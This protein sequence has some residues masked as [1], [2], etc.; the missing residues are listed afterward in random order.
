MNIDNFSEWADAGFAGGTKEELREAAKM[1]GI[2]LPGNISEANIR[3]KLIEKTGNVAPKAEEYVPAVPAVG[4][5]PNL[6]G[7]GKWGGRRYDVMI[8]RPQGIE[9]DY[10][11][12]GWEGP[13]LYIAYNV[14][15][16]IPAPHYHALKN[17]KLNSFTVECEQNK[18]AGVLRTEAVRSDIAYPHMD[19][20]VTPGTENLPGS[21]QEW[22]Q[23][24]AKVREYFART[25][26]AALEEFYAELAGRLA[27][28]KWDKDRLR[29]EVLRCLGPAYEAHGRVEEE[30]AA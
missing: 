28:E 11:G 17:A 26:R 2:D 18:K 5:R 29:F 9:D 24:E 6:T 1:L 12:F 4:Q 10:V 13:P 22:Y 23:E 30:E 14:R 21:L 7:N 27:P 25:K 19:F 16:S 15:T 3:N 8:Q 20:G